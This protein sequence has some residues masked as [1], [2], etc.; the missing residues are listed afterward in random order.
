M[1]LSWQQ[2]TGAPSWFRLPRNPYGK[3]RGLVLRRYWTNACKCCAIKHRC[4]TAKERLITRWEHEHVL[5]A[6][7]VAAA[8]R[9][10]I[11]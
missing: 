1:F 11:A 4:T 6:A 9:R 8:A 7:F 3:E 2:T 10:D 5:E